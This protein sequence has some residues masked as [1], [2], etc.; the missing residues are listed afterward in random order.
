LRGEPILRWR[1]LAPV[2]HHGPLD[3]GANDPDAPEFRSGNPPTY[4]AIRASEW[5]Y[6]EYQDGIREYHERTSDPYELQNTFWSLTPVTRQS[7]HSALAALQACQG[8]EAC[9]ESARFPSTSP[10]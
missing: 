3:Q 1:S 2:E 8:A 10:K 7:L 6:V 9:W 5:V 4:G